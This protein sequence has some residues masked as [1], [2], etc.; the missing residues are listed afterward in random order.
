M[1]REDKWIRYVEPHGLSRIH[2]RDISRDQVSKAIRRPDVVRRAKRQRRQYEKE[3][4][5][6]RRLAVIV[7]EESDTIWVITA[8]WI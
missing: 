1:R 7:E 5:R 3:L 6:K 2:Q 8:F 4:S